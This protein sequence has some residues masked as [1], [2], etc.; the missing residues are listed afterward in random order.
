MI[1]RSGETAAGSDER[2]GSVESS[3]AGL[4]E[5]SNDSRLNFQLGLFEVRCET[6][7]AGRQETTSSATAAA[8][9]GFMRV[10]LICVCLVLLGSIGGCDKEIKEAVKPAAVKHANV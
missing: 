4:T 9:G 7:A 8:L 1:S 3:D 10:M 6:L 5:S 2:W